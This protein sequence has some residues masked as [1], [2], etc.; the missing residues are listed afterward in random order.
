MNITNNTNYSKNNK[1]QQKNIKNK[2]PQKNKNMDITYTEGFLKI[3]THNVRGFNNETKQKL[4]RTF[5]KEHK[6]DIIGITETKLNRNNSKICMNN[7]ESYKTW[8][9]SAEDNPISAGVGIMVKNDLSKYIHKVHKNK[10]RLIAINMKFKGHSDIRIINVYIESNDAKKEERKETVKILLDW[11]HQGKK[12][13]KKLIVMGDFNADP[14]QWT[15]EKTTKNSTKYLILEKLKNENFIDLQKIT[16]EMPLKH[17]W[18]NNNVTRRLDQIWVSREWTKDI[19]NCKVIVNDDELLETDHNIIIAK[20]LS[21]NTLDKRTEA[22]D[23]R[24][25]NKKRVFNYELMNKELWENYQKQ[26]D[27]NL[28]ELNINYELSKNHKEKKDLNR[29]WAL[30]NQVIM[31]AAYK[32]IP[33]E[34]KKKLNKSGRPKLLL[35]TLSL[36]KYI[37]RVVLKINKMLKGNISFDTIDWIKIKEKIINIKKKHEL[38]FDEEDIGRPLNRLDL[39]GIKKKLLELNKLLRTKYKVEETI[40]TEQQIKECSEK[41]CEYIMDEQSKMIDSLLEREK[42]VITLDRCIVK[43]NNG[44]ETLLM[45]KDEVLK[46]VKDHFNKISNMTKHPKNNLEKEWKREY[47]PLNNIDNNYFKDIMD[48][49][50]NEEWNEIL[51]TLPNGKAA[52]LSKISY[53]MIKKSSQKFKDALRKFLDLCLKIGDM[54]NQWNKAIVYPI[55]KPGN[56]ELNLAKIRPII[57]LEIPMKILMKLL[58]NRL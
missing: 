37:I 35:N 40:Y 46:A 43:N 47:E 13:N 44:E 19:Y 25:G 49:I 57:L 42:R 45:E 24:L 51:N 26:L 11:I 23:R 3:A 4:F 18:K 10:G 50:Q 56:W 7:I 15:K 33:S 5:Y 12:E 30:L 22:L 58:T 48:P 53:E 16:N 38:N 2:K 27:L 1:K 20:L 6:I 32:K 52:G 17:T 41:R 34:T 14:E 21:Q 31:K 29:T 28:G 9:E 39:I 54:P 36:A 55:P 8:W